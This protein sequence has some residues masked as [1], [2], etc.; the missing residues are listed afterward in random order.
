MIRQIIKL[1]IAAAKVEWEHWRRP[2]PPGVEVPA[3]I[4]EDARSKMHVE[5]SGS[6]LEPGKCLYC[7]TPVVVPALICGQSTCS[8]FG[9]AKP[10]VKAPR[11]K[12]AA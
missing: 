4:V 3:D 8:M 5:R 1:A 9:D 11:R 6:K 2:T 7:K 10:A 12:K